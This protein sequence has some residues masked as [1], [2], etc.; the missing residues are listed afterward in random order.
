MKLLMILVCK[1]ICALVSPPFKG[2]RAVPPNAP[3]FR[4]PW[5][6]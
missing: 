4:R 3:Q 2:Q 5:T 1:G 6:W